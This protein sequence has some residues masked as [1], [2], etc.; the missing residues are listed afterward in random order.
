L[1][2]SKYHQYETKIGSFFTLYSLL[3]KLFYCFAKAE[4]IDSEQHGNIICYLL[5]SMKMLKESMM[6][7]ESSFTADDVKTYHKICISLKE[8]ELLAKLSLGKSIN[9]QVEKVETL[10]KSTKPDKTA[11]DTLKKLRTSL[12]TISETSFFPKF[13]SNGGG[14]FIATAAYSTSIHPDIDTFR[15]FR[16]RYLLSNSLGRLFVSVYYQV[17]PRIAQYVIHSLYAKK[18][19]R[20]LLEKLASFMRSRQI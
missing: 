2:E 20:F 9:E 14:C 17:S 12:S 15:K 4:K 19:L 3:N 1:A 7:L 16:D 18:I 5:R 6:E 11:D 8:S 13:E 10:I